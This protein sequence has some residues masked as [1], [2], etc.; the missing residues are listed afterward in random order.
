MLPLHGQ[1]TAAIYFSALSRQYLPFSIG[2]V[3]DKQAEI[4]FAEFLLYSFTLKNLFFILIYYILHS[5]L[6]I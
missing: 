6:L 4:I 5:T 1:N 2:D 3:F